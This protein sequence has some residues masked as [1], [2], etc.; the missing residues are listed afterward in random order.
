M[1]LKSILTVLKQFVYSF[2]KPEILQSDNGS[3]YKNDIIS[4][5]CSENNIKQ[6]FSSPYR[7]STNGVVEVS[8]KEIRRHV[9]M[10]FIK[11]EEDFDINNVILDAIN[12]HN[13]NTHTTTK[14]KPIE[15]FSNTS[16]EVFNEAS[17]NIDK[18]FKNKNTYFSE[19]KKGD[20]LLLKKGTYPSRR[21]IKIR[22]SKQDIKGTIATCLEDYSGGLLL[23]KIDETK[24]FYNEGDEL[25][26]DVKYVTSIT[27]DQWNIIIKENK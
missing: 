12:I 24:S 14:Y 4:T 18:A 7:P 25:L 3:E 2:G 5:F 10:E 6:I 13:N 11:N 19:I 16:E 20:K 22:K 27:E 23:I 21:I 15:L 9:I 26:T 17:N 1:M 8:H